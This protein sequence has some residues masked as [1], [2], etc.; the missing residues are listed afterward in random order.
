V[1]ALAIA[2]LTGSFVEGSTSAATAETP[3]A[4]DPRRFSAAIRHPREG[5]RRRTSANAIALATRKQIEPKAFG[6]HTRRSVCRVSS[7]RFIASNV[8]TLNSSV[9]TSWTAAA[10]QSGRAGA[11]DAGRHPAPA[12]SAFTASAYCR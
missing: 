8:L 3:K 7:P 12:R 4:T 2:A 1:R 9:P 6:V 5:R 11:H 10:S